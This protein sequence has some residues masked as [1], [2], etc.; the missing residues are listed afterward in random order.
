MKPKILTSLEL[1]SANNLMTRFYLNN[2]T[3]LSHSV[4]SLDIAGIPHSVIYRKT[5]TNY[6][7]SSGVKTPPAD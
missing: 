6:L 3:L 2:S 1:A 4:S 5:V 7:T